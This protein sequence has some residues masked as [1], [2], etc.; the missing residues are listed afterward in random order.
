MIPTIDGNTARDLVVQAA[1]SR[2]D[3]D[4]AAALTAEF[5]AETIEQGRWHAEWGRGYPGFAPDRTRLAYWRGTLA[6]TMRIH[7]ETMRIGEAR[8]RTGLIAWP[9]T[10]AKYRDKGVA[11]SLLDDAIRYLHE[12]RYHVALLF[13]Q[14]QVHYPFGLTHCLPE[15][16]IDV[17]TRECLKLDN[18]YRVRLGITADTPVLQALHNEND[19][20]VPCSLLRMG[21][22]FARRSRPGAQCHVLL[23]GKGRVGAYFFAEDDGLTL[24]VDEIGLRDG[25]WNEAVLR[26]CADQ[27]ME[28]SAE[29]MR[30]CLAPDHPLAH[31]LQ[32]FP[33][34]HETSVLTAGGGMLACID[35]DDLFQSMIPEWEARVRA[36]K[37]CDA[38]TELTLSIDD[39]TYRIRMT[40]GAIDCAN[41]RGRNRIDVSQD[42]LAGLITGHLDPADLTAQSTFPVGQHVSTIVATLFPKRNPYVWPFDRA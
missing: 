18:P 9:S 13:G 23:D 16:T 8:L 15:Y 12:H 29:T 38:R 27:A 10:G 22:H 31:Y 39:S 6:G 40:H 3:L 21:G 5:N 33:S 7:S 14:P 37:L 17:E 36:S 20:R 24:Q 32:R 30:L 41:E 2:A 35:R 34:K 25:D 11:R 42:E 19:Q 28:T 1:Q 4:D 26:A